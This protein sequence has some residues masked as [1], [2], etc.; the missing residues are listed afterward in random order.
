MSEVLLYKEYLKVLEANKPAFFVMENVR[1]MLS[2]QF[3]N[4]DG[5]KEPVWMR[6]VS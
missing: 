5:T 3:T 6:V 1:G 4:E 2:A